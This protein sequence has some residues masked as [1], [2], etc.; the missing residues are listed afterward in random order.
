M[1]STSWTRLRKT[2]SFLQIRPV[3]LPHLHG[4]YLNWTPARS[5][6][7]LL[8]HINS[9][10]SCFVS[11]KVGSEIDSAQPPLDPF[12]KSWEAFALPR[13]SS[14]TL[15]LKRGRLTT[16]CAVAIG[17]HG[18]GSIS[19]SHFQSLAVYIYV[20]EDDELIREPNPDR[21]DSHVFSAAISLIR[22]LPLHQIQEFVLEDPKQTRCRN[23]SRLKPHPISSS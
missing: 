3:D 15:R 9:P 18:G 13:C 22:K 21:D 14:V 20:D 4:L 5:Q 16:E 2:P 23:R 8:P 17:G 6:Y 10:P 19:I 11:L 1:Q 12:P 7:T